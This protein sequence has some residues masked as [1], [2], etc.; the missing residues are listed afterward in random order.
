MLTARV[1]RGAGLKGADDGGKSSDPFCKLS[2][3]KAN[4]EGRGSNDKKDAIR[5]KTRTCE[6]TLDPEWLESFEFVGV[7]GDS[8]LYMQ[9]FDRDKGYVAGS[10]K[11]SLGTFEVVPQ[12]DVVQY[13]ADKN[14]KSKNPTRRGAMDKSV[15]T[16][17]FKLNGDQSIKGG[18]QLELTWQPFAPSN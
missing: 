10:S 17:T 6:K 9:C 1:I 11:S 4:V 8:K 18:I 12:R 3:P 14:S 7:R 15:V 16:R 2:M 5:Y 13:A